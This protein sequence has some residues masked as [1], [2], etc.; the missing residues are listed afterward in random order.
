LENVMTVSDL[1]DLSRSVEIQQSPPAARSDSDHLTRGGVIRLPEA[2]EISG[3]HTE[4]AG[5]FSSEVIEHTLAVARHVL[6]RSQSM[7]TSSA[8]EEL[9]RES[10]LLR[11]PAQRP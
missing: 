9:A 8:V 11:G 5:R 4:F 2:T 7:V 3:L 1:S 6:E 10:L